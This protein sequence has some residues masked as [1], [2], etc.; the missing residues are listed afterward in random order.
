MLCYF[1]R[2]ILNC[3]Y[4][5]VW[6]C[7]CLCVYESVCVGVFVGALT[8]DYLKRSLKGFSSSGTIVMGGLSSTYGYWKQTIV[9]WKTSRHSYSWAI[10]P[11]PFYTLWLIILYSLS[12]LFPMMSLV[13]TFRTQW[14]LGGSTDM[15]RHHV[16]SNSN[17]IEYLI[18]EWW[19]CR[20]A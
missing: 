20:Q 3:L 9:F 12:T 13:T 2:F 11:A 1:P 19:E 18:G 7:L 17:Q 14:C 6:V 4:L 15:K 5:C 16:Q 8:W 10:S